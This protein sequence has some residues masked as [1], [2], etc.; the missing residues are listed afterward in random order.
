MRRRGAVIL[1]PASVGRN[2]VPPKPDDPAWMAQFPGAE[3]REP[4]I[5]RTMT[6]RGEIVWTIGWA[7]LRPQAP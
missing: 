3:P 5:V 7:L 4:F 6:P 2:M 1:L